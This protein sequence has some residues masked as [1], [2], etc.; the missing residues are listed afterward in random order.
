MKIFNQQS[1]NLLIQQSIHPATYLI[2]IFISNN[3]SILVS[4]CQ[5]IQLYIY[6][7]IHLSNNLSTQ[8]PTKFQTIHPLN[9]VSSYWFT[10]NYHLSIHPS[11][12]S[13]FTT[14]S[15]R[16]TQLFNLH[17]I[18]TCHS[19]RRVIYLVVK[20]RSWAWGVG[21]PTPRKNFSV[22]CL[23]VIYLRMFLLQTSPLKN[24]NKV[25]FRLSFISA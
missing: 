22:L 19:P 9:Y 8:K 16:S 7:S 13:K 15:P 23:S 18:F 20:A 2:C 6:V 12:I 5:Y 21:L 10:S 14:N 1:I 3:L 24:K 11:V 17:S 25:K 4:I